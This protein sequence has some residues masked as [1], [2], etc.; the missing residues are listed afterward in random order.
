M[1][2][3]NADNMKVDPQDGVPLAFALATDKLHHAVA[4]EQEVVRLMRFSLVNSGVELLLHD[5][6]QSIFQT[7]TGTT[8]T[9]YGSTA[10]KSQASKTSFPPV[11]IWLSMATTWSAVIGRLKW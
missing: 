7:T 6:S 9:G 4:F 1:K 5:P 2:H 11:D 10:P 8:V 3:I